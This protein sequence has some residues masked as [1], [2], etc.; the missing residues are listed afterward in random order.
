MDKRQAI[1]TEVLISF[2]VVIFQV[3]GKKRFSNRFTFITC[4]FH[5]PLEIIAEKLPPILRN[6]KLSKSRLFHIIYIIGGAE[7]TLF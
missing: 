5:D 6:Q 3:V 7:L 4:T 2:A 1:R